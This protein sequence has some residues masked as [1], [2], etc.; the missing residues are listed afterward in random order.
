MSRSALISGAMAAYSAAEQVVFARQPSIFEF[1]IAVLSL[2][3]SVKSEPHLSVMHLRKSVSHWLA[4]FMFV[5]FAVSVANCASNFARWRAIA[6]DIVV[7]VTSVVL[8]VNCDDLSA[9]GV[10]S[11]SGSVVSLSVDVVVAR[12]AD[13]RADAPRVP[14]ALLVDADTRPR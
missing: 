7:S 9:M 4:L 14:G 8:T 13:V 11:D 12:I 1:H 6:S 10:D 3:Q 2:L 5:N